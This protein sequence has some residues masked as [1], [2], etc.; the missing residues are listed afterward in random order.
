MSTDENDIDDAQ[1]LL[2]WYKA[3]GDPNGPEYLG[4]GEINAGFELVDAIK[5]QL[6]EEDK[7]T[8]LMHFF[9]MFPPST[10]DYARHE[11]APPLVRNPEGISIAWLDGL[12]CGMA[13]MLMLMAKAAEEAL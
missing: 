12:G 1:A 4:L 3:W 2:D 13:I 6:A 5:S 11:I 7:L 8:G 9:G 10:L